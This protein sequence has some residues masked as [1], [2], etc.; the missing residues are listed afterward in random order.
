MIRFGHRTRNIA[1]VAAVAL[2]AVSCG[3]GDATDGDASGQDRDTSGDVEV[4]SGGAGENVAVGSGD[5]GGEADAS[6][7]VGGDRWEFEN[8]ACIAGPTSLDVLASQGLIG[9]S[10][11]PTVVI[12]I[13]GDWAGTGDGQIQTFDFTMFEGPLT[14]PDTSWSAS[15]DG[16]EPSFEV[17]GNRFTAQAKFDDGLTPGTTEAVE[18]AFEVTCPDLIEAPPAT[19]T[20]LPDFTESGFVTVGGETFVFTFD[21]PG[22]CGSDSGDGKVG[23]TGVLVDDPTRQVVFTYATAEMSTDGEPAL[24]LI[25]YDADGNQMWYSA[26]GY[27]GDG[28]GSIESITGDANSVMVSGE[29]QRSGTEELA[30][31]T[32]EA[33]CNQ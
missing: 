27:F 19:T 13:L 10:T 32:A 26:V 14:S 15:L 29:L 25:I 21:P 3:G 24:Q 17:D 5:S 20:T 16:G 6:F 11:D 4:D 23:A 22:R 8:L 28:V 30:P 12:K 18:G 2:L 33:T 1:A 7:A 9:V 31:F